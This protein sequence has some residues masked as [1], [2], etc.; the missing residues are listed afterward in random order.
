MGVIPPPTILLFVA[1]TR[2]SVL[3][4]VTDAEIEDAAEDVRFA[5][6][7]RKAGFLRLLFP[8]KGNPMTKFDEILGCIAYLKLVLT[9][10]NKYGLAMVG[11]LV[12][13]TLVLLFTAPAYGL[14]GL[15]IISAIIGAV[16]GSMRGAQGDEP[17][18]WVW[19]GPIC[20]SLVLTVIAIFL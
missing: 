6:E 16:L 5:A 17:P 18:M 1:A 19:V 9:G 15:A 2:R 10:L 20:F 13:A 4:E 7:A 3:P 8:K 11:S 12:A 14:F